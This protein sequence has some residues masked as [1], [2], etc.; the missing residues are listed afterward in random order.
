MTAHSPAATR[1]TDTV[2][3]ELVEQLT[4]TLRYA[5]ERDYTGWDLYDGESSRLLQALPVDNRWVNLAFQQLPRRAPVNVRPLLLV[6]QRRNF[7]GGALFALANFAAYDL[8]GERRYRNEARTLV[9]WL[10]EN[11]SEGYAG[12]CGGHNHFVQGL[13]KRTHPNTPGIVGTSYAVKALVEAGRRVD[14]SYRETAETAA[15]F[16]FEDLAYREHPDGAR[17]RY[18]P[19]DPETHFTLNANALGAR[20][21][22]DLYAV[23]GDARHR[24]GA[25]E[26]LDYVAARQTDRGGWPYRDPPETSH[27]SMDNFHNG[28]IV[29]SLRRFETVTGTDRYAEQLDHGEEFYRGLFDPDGAPHFDESNRYPHDVHSSAQGGVVFSMLGDHRRARSVLRWA[30]EHLSDGE[31]RFYHERR[32]FFTKRTTL[33]RWC[34]AWMAYGLARH[35]LERADDGGF[36]V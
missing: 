24:E 32:R 19:D 8:T 18:K 6:E 23:T 10:V 22:T 21:L 1:E 25:R 11:R 26:I 17:I 31:G 28:Y 14:A 36:R 4:A 30:V 16:V 7:L 5:R 20:L 33:M 27:L 13:E 35:L 29:E 2:S 15:S 3:P 12:Y 34:Q 9:D